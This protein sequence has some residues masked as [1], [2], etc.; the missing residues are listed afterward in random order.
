MPADLEPIF[1]RL[2]GALERYS[3]PLAART[4]TV[5]GKS[6]YHLWS[7]KDVVVDGRPRKEVF[8]A[9]LIVQKGYVGLYYM[10]VYAE[11]ER[12]E[13]FA[14]ELLKRLEGKSCF[15]IRRLDDELFG[16]I[17]QALANGFALY[18]ERGWV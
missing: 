16:Q 13:L 12:R 10:P 3:P 8:F 7:E 4:G 9:G 2:R 6:D 17:E 14:P 18:R 5:E 11:P 1:Q 15:H